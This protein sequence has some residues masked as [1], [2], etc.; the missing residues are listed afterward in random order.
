LLLRILTLPVDMFLLLFMGTLLLTMRLF[1]MRW[2]D[3]YWP[4]Y[5]AYF[6]DTMSLGLYCSLA[7]PGAQ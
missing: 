3:K 5:R 1:N 2:S 6:V 7:Y 4:S